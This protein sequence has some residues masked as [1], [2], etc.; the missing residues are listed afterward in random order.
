VLL[1]A[2]LAVAFACCAVLVPS[3]GAAGAAWALV[4]ASVVQAVW[5]A[6]ALSRFRVRASRA[7]GAV[8]AA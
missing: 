1:S 2:T 5:S 6:V 3:H 7:P 4:A 8:E